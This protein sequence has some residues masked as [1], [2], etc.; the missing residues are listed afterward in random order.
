MKSRLQAAFIHLCISSAI[1]GSF[2]WLV[3][4]VWYPHPYDQLIGVWYALGI[5]VVVDLVLGPLLTL[6]VFNLKKPFKELRRDLMVIAAIQLSALAWGVHVTYSVRPVMNVFALKQFYLFRLKDFSTIEGAAK[7]LP[8]I[9]E[10][11]QLVYSA[12]ESKNMQEYDDVV[13]AILEGNADESLFL[14]PSKYLSLQS[15]KEL[16]KKKS[17]TL[18]EITSGDRVSKEKIDAFIKEHGSAADSYLYFWV[19]VER[20]HHV[21]VMNSQLDEVIDA[22]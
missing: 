8:G 5:I 12:L 14:D 4:F 16:V 22:L 19:T 2:L 1:I 10:K 18:S 3:F 17:R 13:R 7:N 15:H 11:P 6:I 21:L 9:F 20:S